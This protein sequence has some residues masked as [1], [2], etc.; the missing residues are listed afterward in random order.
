[1]KSLILAAVSVVALGIGGVGVGYAMPPINSLPSSSSGQTTGWMAGY[2]VPATP[3][4]MAR[5]WREVKLARLQQQQR[6]AR[7]NT[8][9]E[10]SSVGDGA[11]V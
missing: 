2:G 8:S 5:V 7:T 1:M 3:A 9:Q 4:Q 11:P 6:H 10:P